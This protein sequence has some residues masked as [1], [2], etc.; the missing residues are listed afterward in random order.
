MKTERT[1]FEKDY[2]RE[3]Y[4]GD[5]EKR[6][7]ARKLDYYI[8]Q[9]LCEKSSGTL[10]DVGCAYGCFLSRARRYF[11]VS[12]CD[13]SE[14]A[15]GIA[16]ERLPG[17]HIFRA[18]IGELSSGRTFDVVTCF[19]VLEHVEDL[20]KAFEKLS[21]SLNPGGILAVTVPVYDGLPGRMV[22][23][24][25]RDET[26]VWKQSGDFWRNVMRSQGFE[27]VR[28][29]GLWRYFLLSR[30]YI[31]FGGKVWRKFSPALLLIGART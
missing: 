10:L 8:R 24:L 27:I 16:R 28:D 13:I 20:P 23:M 5:Y 3:A 25:D 15:V 29:I 17:R 7:P 26:H 6:N 31:F 19:D 22:G 9:I 11:D 12:G 4:G 30:V 21:G 18:D 1:A 14:H 2:F